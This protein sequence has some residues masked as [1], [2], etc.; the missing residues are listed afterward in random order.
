DLNGLE[1]LDAVVKYGGFA[2]AAEHLH[3]VQSAISH[4]IQKLEEQ[5]GVSLF[6][7]DGYR[8]QLTA[9]GEAILAE[10]R[11]LLAQA[12]HV[13]SVARQYSQGWEPALVIIVD[14]ILPLD[15]TLAALKT[16]ATERVPTRIQVKVEFIRGVQ[17]RFEKDSGD[18]MLVTD[19]AADPNLHE[20]ALPPLDCILCVAPTHP[21]GG[22]KRVSLAELQDHVEMSV[23]HS[24]EEQGYD[25]HL[26]GCE[27]AFYLS[28]H[29][30][31]KQAL[32][33]GVGFGWMPMY[34]I[35]NELK[36]GTLRELRY[37][38]GSRCRFTPRLVH[39]ADRQLGRAG[40]RFVEL[41]R[42]ATWPQT[43][44]GRKKA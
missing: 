36:A 12:E 14:G 8:V 5:L 40:Q 9:T 27:R 17:A 11:R 35:H 19:Y 39:R 33:M 28:S 16:L 13:R 21:L 38:G 25:R 29:H 22:G 18:L 3:K 30:A 31:K 43:Q 23:Q 26:F 41:L 37:V 10:S 7:R 42:S 44:L 20:E 2:R 6:N 1:A 15:P 34:L 32:L 24:S 4:Q